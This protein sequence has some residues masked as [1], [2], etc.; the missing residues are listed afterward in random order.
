MSRLTSSV[1]MVA[2]GLKS[3]TANQRLKKSAD[4]LGPRLEEVANATADIQKWDCPKK[5]EEAVQVLEAGKEFGTK[6]H[7]LLHDYQHFKLHEEPK[8]WSRDMLRGYLFPSAAAT[9]FAVLLGEI[10]YRR[11]LKMKNQELQKKLSTGSTK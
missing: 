2:Y 3:H 9:T 10:A 5:I 7:K 6:L 8:Y 1:R 11:H 4:K